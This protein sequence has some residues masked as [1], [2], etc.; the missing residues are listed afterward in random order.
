MGKGILLGTV[1]KWQS[2]YG[3]RT[4]KPIRKKIGFSEYL[5]Y[6]RGDHFCTVEYG[7]LGFLAVTWKNIEPQ[8][9]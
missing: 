1:T 8:E 2:V 3:N 4:K 7:I 5:P 6:R 9:A